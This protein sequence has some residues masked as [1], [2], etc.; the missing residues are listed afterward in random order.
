MKYI[1]LLPLLLISVTNSLSQDIQEIKDLPYYTGTNNEKHK[2]NLVLPAEA[3]APLLLWIHGGAWSGG[4]RKFE[5][6]FA[7]KLA[8]KGIAVAVMSY[9]LSPAEF[10]D[11]P[12]RDGI[13]HPEHIR[14]VA[15]AFK[16]VY[17]NA[18]KYGYDQEKL[19]IS[20]FSAGG[21]LSALFAMDKSYSDAVDLPQNALTGCI[22][23]SGTF[24]IT[25]YYEA[26]EN[27]YGSTFARQHVNGVFGPFSNFQNASPSKYIENLDVPMLVITDGALSLYADQFRKALD[28]ADREDI[29]ISYYRSFSH[30]DL[31]ND[32]L[33]EDSS[34]A[35]KEIVDF[36]LKNSES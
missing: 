18:S 13:Q 16:W 20:G 10:R 21:H 26:I 11:P 28:N 27:A 15:R 34:E 6:P 4:D 12:K 2:L 17:S 22:P 36:V 7:R 5:M 25:H 9:R 1:F 29:K 31:Y 33:F 3:N 24:D 8:E 35:R 32:L 30:D 14:D 23:V 19:F